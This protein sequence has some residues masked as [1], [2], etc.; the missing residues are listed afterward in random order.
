MRVD[1]A[2]IDYRIFS[3]FIVSP[4]FY[5]FQFEI[6]VLPSVKPLYVYTDPEN[7]I[8]QS[9]KIDLDPIL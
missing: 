6:L 8:E 7:E 5:D 4:A 3:S 1:I 2:A 9:F